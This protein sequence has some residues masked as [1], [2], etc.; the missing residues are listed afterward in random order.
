LCVFHVQATSPQEEEFKAAS[1]GDGENYPQQLED[2]AISKGMNKPAYSVVPQM[3]AGKLSYSCFVT[4]S[5]VCRETA[6]KVFFILLQPVAWDSSVSTATGCGL[7]S[8]GI[9][10]Q[11]R[12]DFLLLSRL[13]LGPTQPAIQWVDGRLTSPL[14][15]YHP[16][17]T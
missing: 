15:V 1:F 16:V 6:I 14:Q 3:A 12:Q 17:C 10:S 11:W 5:T 4:V 8:P 13:A 9:E 2:L 7:D